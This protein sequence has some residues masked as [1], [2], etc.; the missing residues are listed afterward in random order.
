[1]DARTGQGEI[2]RLG[3]GD[4][5]TVDL[6]LLGP[7][8]LSY[9][10]VVADGG[11]TYLLPEMAQVGPQRLV[12][13]AFGTGQAVAHEP[14]QGLEDAHLWDPTL[15]QH[16]GRWW[17]FAGFP[18]SATDVV[19]LWLADDLFGPYRPHP[20]SPIVLDP[21]RASDGWPR[22]ATGGRLFRPGQDNR[23]GY[24]DGVVLSE[25]KRLDP[26][27][28]EEVPTTRLTVPGRRGPQT[29]VQ[30]GSRLLV[31]LYTEA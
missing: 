14:L 27:G 12:R 26:D 15:L 10:H 1:M 17:L 5:A 31:D 4:A 2:L 11:E 22:P 6:S 7:G 8:H 19:H 29:V 21:S 3:Q 30:V 13:L 16:E 18:G 25:I 20:S 23:R 28:Y 9:P 24:G